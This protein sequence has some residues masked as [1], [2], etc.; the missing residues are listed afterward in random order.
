MQS[1]PLYGK[2][3]SVMRPFQC[4]LMKMSEKISSKSVIAG[5]TK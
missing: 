3:S 2:S 4:C 5:S 1:S